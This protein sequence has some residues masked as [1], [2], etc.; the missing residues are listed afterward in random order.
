MGELAEQK[1]APERSVDKSADSSDLE[2]KDSSADE[3]KAAPEGISPRSQ[4]TLNSFIRTFLE[5]AGKD[6]ADPNKKV[7]TDDLDKIEKEIFEGRIGEK[8]LTATRTIA[9]WLGKSAVPKILLQLQQEGVDIPP[10]GPYTIPESYRDGKSG[11][12]NFLRD[13]SEGIANNTFFDKTKE[14]DALR[15]DNSFISKLSRAVEWV[16]ES[17]KEVHKSLEARKEKLLENEIVSL[18]T[19]DKGFVKEP[20]KLRAWLDKSS[21]SEGDWAKQAKERLD[22]I[23]KIKDYAY[24]QAMLAS[25]NPKLASAPPDGVKVSKA[26]N[27]NFKVDIEL[28]PNMVPGR[29]EFIS[30]SE[31]WQK[32]LKERA[33][34]IDQMRSEYLMAMK[35]SSETKGMQYVLSF[36]LMP[37]QN[38]FVRVNSKNEV[39]Q[40]LAPNEVKE[41][42][43][44]YNIAD[45]DMKIRKGYDENGQETVFVK[46]QLQLRVGGALNYLDAFTAAVGQPIDLPERR[47]KPDDFVMVNDGHKPQFIQA[48]DLENWLSWQ[49]IFHRSE[50]VLTGAMDATMLA[51]G[52]IEF[53]GATRVGSKA[54]WHMVSGLYHASVG[55]SGV[56][57]NAYFR[58]SEGGQFANEARGYLFLATASLDLTRLSLKAAS[59][60]VL[61]ASASGTKISESAMAIQK[62]LEATKWAAVSEQ[63]GKVATWSGAAFVPIMY[64]GAEHAVSDLVDAINK[65]PDSLQ[66]ATKYM[67]PREL[68]L[69]SGDGINSTSL[70]DLNRTAKQL[71]K[72][73]PKEALSLISK[74]AELN[75][76]GDAKAI[77]AFK[78][79]LMDL[80]K[81]NR[82]K[83]VNMGVNRELEGE[84]AS[85][86]LKY[87]SRQDQDRQLAAAIALIH[88]S[89]KPDG[90]IDDPLVARTIDL[91]S[92]MRHQETKRFYE[93][94]KAEREQQQIKI[95]DLSRIL[96]AATKRTENEKDAISAIAAGELLLNVQSSSG[97]SARDYAHTLSKIASTNAL[98]ESARAEALVRIGD[99]AAAFA[100]REQNGE[101]KLSSI[102]EINSASLN[103]ALHKIANDHATS[104]PLR[105]LAAGISFANRAGSSNEQRAQFRSYFAD[106]FSKSPADFAQRSQK[107]LEA[108]IASSKSALSTRVI[109]AETLQK[110]GRLDAYLEKNKQNDTVQSIGETAKTLDRSRWIAVADKERYQ[111]DSLAVQSWKETRRLFDSPKALEILDKAEQFALAGSDQQRQN[112][113]K[114]ELL[115][116]IF[117][118][119]K[120]LAEGQVGV[121]V[122]DKQAQVAALLALS[123]LSTEPSNGLVAKRTVEVP[124]SEMKVVED[125]GN[126]PE[127]KTFL[128]PAKT[129]EQSLS[130]A[131]LSKN[132][133]ALLS[134]QSSRKSNLALVETL[135][136]LGTY[137]GQELVGSLQDIVKDGEPSSSVEKVL[138]LM[139]LAKISSNAKLQS[140]FN[141]KSTISGSSSAD[142]ERFIR[143]TLRV[144][145]DPK[146]KAAAAGIIAVLSYP[147]AKERNELIQ[148]MQALSLSDAKQFSVGIERML[149]EDANSNSESAVKA[150]LLLKDLADKGTNAESEVMQQLAELASIKPLLK[151]KSNA[152]TAIN[153]EDMSKISTGPR[154][155][156]AENIVQTMRDISSPGSRPQ[157]A[158]ETSQYIDAIAKFVP[159]LNGDQRSEIEQNM[160]S[161]ADSES[162]H[163]AETRITAI[164]FLQ[165]MG[166]QSSIATLDKLIA[167]TPAQPEFRLIYHGFKSIR[168]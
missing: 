108:L 77:D 14:Q 147:S 149:K 9:D 1:S 48:K 93:P 101:R 50:K 30:Q 57:N 136:K 7:S 127:E 141:D 120:E 131:E 126:G 68:S 140:E 130:T 133:E 129:V 81:P 113:F 58:E 74:A 67:T 28:A 47:Y 158:T 33:P 20:E 5:I 37:V 91:P 165:E 139:Q 64:R 144:S 26:E 95:E 150:A 103:Q 21:F 65:T 96:S 23:H 161:I 118:D 49:K 38:G 66:Q 4:Q 10:N 27:G 34:Q 19:D 86:Y 12:V 142:I 153:L 53:A 51:T 87:R 121:L 89:R 29:P 61:G 85:S 32:W 18:F 82:D 90:K 124:A 63:A 148:S 145:S 163:S 45:T 137:S 69:T 80:F 60:T 154:L 151:D 117:P 152:M 110:I 2:I 39:E 157:N 138:S 115:G 105:M 22:L 97:Y 122:R 99:I 112:Q 71:E 111:T 73:L 35:D 42:D 119:G 109:A 135:L 100:T 114:G 167:G 79:S 25:T 104:E 3:L 128:V 8:T 94:V 116:Q 70:T 155:H 162:Q 92:Y 159:L 52:T 16:S 59:K 13:L 166:S 134:D 132:I 15:L 123:R 24:A 72:T 46:P 76:S 36:Q 11:A 40:L 84:R 125:W 102:R 43:K 168:K 160:I 75:S 31:S 55:A 107:D 6:N 98:P 83:I 146:V 106:S 62:E 44:K 143:E 164:R 88:L 54:A 41:G 17:N 78:I 56:I 156:L